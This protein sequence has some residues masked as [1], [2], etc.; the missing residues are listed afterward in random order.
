MKNCKVSIG[1]IMGEKGVLYN[2]GDKIALDDTTADL[3]VRL[4]YVELAV[5]PKPTIPPTQKIPSVDVQ[6][7]TPVAEQSKSK[8]EVAK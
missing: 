7:S 1:P 6:I 2:S 3:F 5:E 4:G 8:S